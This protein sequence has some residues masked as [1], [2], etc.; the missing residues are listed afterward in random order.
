MFSFIFKKNVLLSSSSYGKKSTPNFEL[1]APSKKEQGKLV[2]VQV[3]QNVS[4]S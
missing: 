4:S 2:A 1:S 3:P